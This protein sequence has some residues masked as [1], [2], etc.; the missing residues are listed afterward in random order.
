MAGRD[1]TKHNG[2]LQGVYIV[3]TAIASVES[4]VVVAIGL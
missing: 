3:R 2:N 4:G 1:V